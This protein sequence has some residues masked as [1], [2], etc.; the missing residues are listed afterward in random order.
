LRR[1]GGSNFDHYSLARTYQLRENLSIMRM[2]LK[3]AGPVY[4]WMVILISF[5]VLH[6]ILPK[7]S[8]FELARNLL[9]AM[10]DWMIAVDVLFISLTLPFFDFRFRR[11]AVEIRLF[12]WIL[13]LHNSRIASAF[14]VINASE[15]RRQA[16]DVY[17]NWLDKDLDRNK[18]LK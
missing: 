16:A 3:M 10:F 13:S 9:A 18:N 1:R 4:T 2:I 14:A 15:D 11:I 17:F 12:R 5:F 6:M 8:G 7:T